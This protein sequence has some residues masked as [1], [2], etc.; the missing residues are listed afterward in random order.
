MIR[1]V[2]YG[3]SV[4]AGL[5]FAIQ[6]A[7]GE[8]DPDDPKQ[9]ALGEQ[10]YAAEC[11]ACHGTRLEG[12]AEWKVAGPDGIYPAPPHDETG[13][14]WHHDD[15]L[16]FDYTK[17]GGAAVIG[18]TFKSGMPGFGGQL[19]DDQIRAVLAFIKSEWPEEIRARQEER[20]GG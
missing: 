14:T 4:F 13:H 5:V 16:L 2:L 1:G 17:R 7:A 15:A 8:I 18:G 6:A 19:S 12:A 20:H 11:A 9:V 10:L 3:A